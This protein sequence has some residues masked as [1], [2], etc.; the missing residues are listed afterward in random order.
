MR[1]DGSAS[2]P[3]AR[4]PVHHLPQV[5]GGTFVMP[6]AARLSLPHLHNAYRTKIGAKRIHVVRA[7][8]GNLKYRALRLETG[9]YA[10][11]SEGASR[12]CAFC[13]YSI[14]TGAIVTSVACHLFSPVRCSLPPRAGF[15]H[16]T[17][18][19]GVVYNASN[20]EL[21]RHVPLCRLSRTGYFFLSSVAVAATSIS[22]SLS[23][24]PERRCA[25]ILS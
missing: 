16:K 7:R 3:R 6:T 4:E 20:N 2:A 12:S 19:I 14:S 17:R 25:R 11:G 8:G 5:L 9:N 24:L 21:V 23:L 22:F 18:I 15:A 13:S 1:A 10:W